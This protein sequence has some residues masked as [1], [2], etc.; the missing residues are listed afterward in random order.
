MNS[1]TAKKLRKL[2]R[3]I[4]G[5]KQ[6]TTYSVMQLPL[7][8]PKA[9]ARWGKRGWAPMIWVTPDCARGIYHQMKRD[10]GHGI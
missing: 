1:K 10:M 2:A 3:Q 9:K 7:N 4:A 8:T 5:P 6:A